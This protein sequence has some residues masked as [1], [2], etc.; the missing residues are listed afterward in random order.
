MFEQDRFQVVGTDPVVV[1]YTTTTF[2]AADNLVALAQQQPQYISHTDDRDELVR[3]I[4]FTISGDL[5]IFVQGIND[6]FQA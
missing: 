4:R 1:E 2:V 5:D 6:A 3:R